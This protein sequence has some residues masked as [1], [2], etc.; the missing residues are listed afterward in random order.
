MKPPPNFNTGIASTTLINTTKGI[1]LIP[2]I[3]LH[4]RWKMASG[5]KIVQTIGNDFHFQYHATNA[6]GMWFPFKPILAQNLC[7]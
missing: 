3:I 2:A 6:D 7:V 4:N 5:V 1:N